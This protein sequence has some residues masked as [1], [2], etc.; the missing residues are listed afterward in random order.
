LYVLVVTRLAVAAF[1]QYEARVLTGPLIPA[2][3]GRYL[4]LRVK[5]RG[6]SRLPIRI[7][8][9]PAVHDA[10]RCNL[11]SIECAL[12]NEGF[13]LRE[14]VKVHLERYLHPIRHV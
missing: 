4:R 5:V 11:D 3:F 6:E 8:H 2:R 12:R 14:R 13:F 1:D 9:E 7:K 10:A